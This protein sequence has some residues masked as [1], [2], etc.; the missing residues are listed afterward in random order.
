M[1]MAN[2]NDENI[3]FYIIGKNIKEQRKLKGL[4]QEQLADKSNY[5]LGFIGNLESEKVFQTISIGSLYHIAKV[6]EIPITDLLK[7]LP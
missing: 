7:D 6:L 3:I 4:T 2:S 1:Q 5:T